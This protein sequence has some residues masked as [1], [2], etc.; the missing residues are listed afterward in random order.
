MEVVKKDPHGYNV[1]PVS[2][3]SYSSSEEELKEIQRASKSLFKETA[4]ELAHVKER[5]CT[6]HYSDSGEEEFIQ[7]QIKQTSA[8]KDLSPTHH[9]PLITKQIRGNVSDA[10]NEGTDHEAEGTI[11]VLEDSADSCHLSQEQ[12]GQVMEASS[13]Y[14]T[15]LLNNNEREETTDPN[16]TNIISVQQNVPV[17][18]ISEDDS[19]AEDI[20]KDGGS[21]SMQGSHITSGTTSPTSLS[22]LGEESDS[23]LCF[24]KE[25]LEGKQQ[26][27]VKHRQGQPLQTIVDSSE[28]EEILEEG[29]I[30]EQEIQAE[31][32]HTQ[33]KKSY[34]K[35]NREKDKL[36]DHPPVNHS[37]LGCIYQTDELLPVSEIKTYETFSYSNISPSTE[38]EQENVVSH[39]LLL[40]DA[41]HDVGEKQLKSADEAYEEMMQK[42]QE[43]KAMTKKI[44]PPDIEPLYG[45]ML[46]EDYVYESLV[47]EP[48]QALAI[49]DNTTL[50]EY[51]TNVSVP[52]TKR[53]LR[54]LEEAYEEMRKNRELLLKDQ[55]IE[56][57]QVKKSVPYRNTTVTD[58]CYVNMSEN[59]EFTQNQDE[60]WQWYAET[61]NDE[62][63]NR[64]KE[65]M[66]PGTSPSQSTPLSPVSPLSLTEPLDDSSEVIQIPSSGEE[67]NDMNEFAPEPI[68]CTM[69]PYRP[70]ATPPQDQSVKNVLYPIP[71]LKITQCSSGEEEADGEEGIM[72]E[73][74]KVV[75]GIA[76]CD[77]RSEGDF[78]FIESVEA[79]SIESD[80]TSVVSEVPLSKSSFEHVSFASWDSQSSPLSPPS[81]SLDLSLSSCLIDQTAEQDSIP[82][83]T[84]S[85][86]SP[87][88]LESV[89]VIISTADLKP[90]PQVQSVSLSGISNEEFVCFSQVTAS[91]QQTK[92]VSTAPSLP[93][94]PATKPPLASKPTLVVST[95][96]SAVSGSSVTIQA[97]KPSDVLMFNPPLN[98]EQ[99]FISE[100]TTDTIIVTI[101][102][103]VSQPNTFLQ[104]TPTNIVDNSTILSTSTV[105]SMS[106]HEQITFPVS[107]KVMSPTTVLATVP[108]ISDSTIAPA[109][110]S[111]APISCVT[112][113]PFVPGIMFPTPECPIQVPS[114]DPTPRYTGREHAPAIVPE[115][116]P[117][118]VEIPEIM[119]STSKYL[120]HSTGMMSTLA[121][122]PALTSTSSLYEGHIYAPTAVST[123]CLTDTLTTVQSISFA[124]CLPSSL[125]EPS[126]I[127]SESTKPSTQHPHVLPNIPF[128][129]N[130]AM[131]PAIKIP[132]TC[133]D[134]DKSLVEATAA[135][136]LPVAVSQTCQS[137]EQADPKLFPSINLAVA[138][139]NLSSQPT[140]SKVMDSQIK[141]QSFQ[142]A[143]DESQIVTS[144]MQTVQGT[145][146]VV[147][148]VENVPMIKEQTHDIITN[149]METSV[150]QVRSL[151]VVVSVSP[152]ISSDVSPIVGLKVSLPSDLAFVSSQL[153]S[154]VT[155][156]RERADKPVIE[157]PPPPAASPPALL[158]D[159]LP[160]TPFNQQSVVPTTI[161]SV[162]SIASQVPRASEKQI[163]TTIHKSPP[164]VPPKPFTLPGGLVFSH[165]SIESVKP[166]V[167]SK[168]AVGHAATLPRTRE[169]PK[170]LTLSLTAPTDIKH[171][172]SSPKSPL[173]PR[174]AK[175]LETYVVITL[176]SEP[177]SPVEGIT[178][179]APIH[180]QSLPTSKQQG[181]AIDS[182]VFTP[183]VVCA[184]ITMISQYRVDTLPTLVSSP[185]L[186]TPFIPGQSGDFATDVTN[187]KAI[188]S[189][190]TMI[191]TTD[192][193]GAPSSAIPVPHSVATS[194][195]FVPGIEIE[196]QPMKKEMYEQKAIYSAPPV[197]TTIYSSPTVVSIPTVTSTVAAKIPDM[198]IEPKINSVSTVISA[199]VTSTVTVPYSLPP[200]PAFLPQTETDPVVPIKNVMFEEKSIYSEIVIPVTSPDTLHTVSVVSEIP[201][202]TIEPKTNNVLSSVAEVCATYPSGPQANSQSVVP[203]SLLIQEIPVESTS[204]AFTVGITSASSREPSASHDFMQGHE[205]QMIH[206]GYAAPITTTQL[207]ITTDN[208]GVHL[209]ETKEEAKSTNGQPSD[210]IQQHHVFF[211]SEQIV[212]SMSAL[213]YIPTAPVTFAQLK[214]SVENQEIRGTDN[215]LS[216]SQLFSTVSANEQ[217]QFALPN[218]LAQVVTTEVQRTTTVS[219]VQERIPLE[220]IS[221]PNCRQAAPKPRGKTHCIDDVIDLTTLKVSFSNTDKG[222]DLTAPESNLQSFL[223]E[224]SSRQIT[225]VQP[226]IVNLSAE[227]IPATTLSVVTNSITVV[228]CTSA[229][230]CNKNITID[231][232]PNLQ[233]VTSM[234]APL[235]TYKPFEPLAQI[236]YRPVNSQPKPTTNTEIPINLSCGLAETTAPSALSITM[237]PIICTPSTVPI[238]IGPS[239]GGAIDLTI[240]KPKRTMLAITASTGVVTSVVEEDVAPVDLT[241]GRRTV[242]CDILY[243]LPFT[244][245]CRTQPPVTTTDK[246]AGLINY[247]QHHVTTLGLEDLSNTKTLGFGINGEQTDLATKNGLVSQYDAPN[248]AIDLTSAKMQRGQYYTACVLWY[249]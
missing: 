56:N 40:M 109:F 57:T 244:G 185:V 113:I 34:K 206:P 28:D 105:T 96:E 124:P 128:A 79:Q 111:Q 150:Q 106:T 55:T 198:S 4:E 205:R 60:N 48:A 146:F 162:K 73:H 81:T 38:S 139:V 161:E 197:C 6:K 8:D 85:T 87:K 114:L 219:V 242:C 237:A 88:T 18:Q 247:D 10:D 118:I 93:G 173:S 115:P 174:F 74:Q 184:P 123:C 29:E 67:D 142:L 45:G 137:I 59:Y 215:V 186:T 1:F 216:M 160:N 246:K 37:E 5:V 158:P 103:G 225:A 166:S 72:Q 182:T 62:M 89:S 95:D 249:I 130:T 156:S 193:T 217:H 92:N 233:S 36:L 13:V 167:I 214:K 21:S 211:E 245:S 107:S 3:E 63:L 98:S 204:A 104:M 232:H 52:E 145:N 201:A 91:A 136:D 248:G 239:A 32:D 159:S 132:I 140:K 31:T 23:S 222:M 208:L 84:C 151:P 213:A 76:Q 122:T 134:E 207:Q 223:N 178:T 135:H 196:I 168:S 235:K 49:D 183:P 149:T 120:I 35:S 228:T 51:L 154:H 241:A 220:P 54:T 99:C 195:A 133:V 209:L 153:E 75:N 47:E 148:S 202:M 177:G 82:P 121:Q 224:S 172:I 171:S 64:E 194:I 169:P 189:A 69:E 203:K 127:C 164:P 230:T 70:E 187:K 234:S 227:I 39:H 42:A 17:S 50:D 100:H 22:S 26:R 94:M 102:D 80:P 175:T 226:E 240:S 2:P 44:T 238:H 16:S 41:M 212:P 190:Y 90:A 236:V 155:I 77:D 126:Y 101:D 176:P 117:C 144:D 43:L 218:L 108:L 125:V 46:I 210:Q 165:K 143:K 152:V 221:D 199:P 65:I 243:R 110:V 19:I 20:S 25:N 15:V 131:T 68:E 97:P 71:D 9:Q 188:T 179:Q 119:S 27:K 147:P 129:D 83:K 170:A 163:S 30:I 181:L 66:T 112:S 141:T 24:K 200:S 229:F 12:E 33:F 53:K 180:R 116:L 86:E 231:A 157:F 61:A 58:T 7:T 191:S 192:V 11:N 14:K 78:E 138:F